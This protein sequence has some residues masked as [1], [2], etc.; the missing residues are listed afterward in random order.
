MCE[1]C[2]W[3]NECHNFD[4]FRVGCLDF[5]RDTDDV[6]EN[7]N[8]TQDKMIVGRYVY[9]NSVETLHFI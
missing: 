2:K 5:E 4:I 6:Y 9:D 1:E 8:E 7:L 3:K